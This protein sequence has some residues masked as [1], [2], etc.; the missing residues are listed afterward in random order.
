V[1][2]AISAASCAVAEQVEALA[3]APT[4]MSGF[5]ARMIARHRPE[6]PIFAVSPSAHTQRRLALVWGVDCHLVPYAEET[7]EMIAATL[8]VLRAEGLAAGGKVVITAGV[9]FGVKS[10]TNLIQV[11][12]LQD[13]TPEGVR[14]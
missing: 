10:H 6:T 9:P 1:T 11:Q 7:D 8:D 12:Q 3:I 14:P 13:G 4:T 5:T 2:E